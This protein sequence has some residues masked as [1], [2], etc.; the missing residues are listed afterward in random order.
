MQNELLMFQFTDACYWMMSPLTVNLL[1][2]ANQRSGKVA[3]R[4]AQVPESGH[5]REA[6]AEGIDRRFDVSVGM[7]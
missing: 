1:N 5:S 3:N 6:F 7:S 4:P 2:D